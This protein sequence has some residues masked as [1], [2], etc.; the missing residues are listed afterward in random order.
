MRA[1]EFIIEDTAV[2][3]GDLAPVVAPLGAIQRRVPIET[4]FDKYKNRKKKR[5]SKNERRS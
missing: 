3:S 1:T 2:V 4:L 5:V